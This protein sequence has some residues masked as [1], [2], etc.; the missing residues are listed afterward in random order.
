[1]YWSLAPQ[2]ESQ[3]PS[4]N[5]G[6]TA[7]RL[8]NLRSPETLWFDFLALGRLGNQPLVPGAWGRGEP[9]SSGAQAAPHPSLGAVGVELRGPRKGC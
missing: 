8:H 5:T 9:T 4:N 6:L 1:M 2:E 7:L 3:R